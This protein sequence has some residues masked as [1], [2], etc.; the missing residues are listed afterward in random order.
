MPETI[1]VSDI[2]GQ[3]GV[4]DEL[5]K[6]IIKYPNAHIVFGG[7]YIDGH[8]NGHQVV[9]R[10]FAYQ[11]SWPGKVTVLK[12]NH[13]Q[14]M[15]NYLDD[16]EDMLWFT[17]GGKATM[18]Q[19]VRDKYGRA[20][21]VRYMRQDIKV[22]SYVEYIKNLPTIYETENI[23]VVHAG[24]DWS[25]ESPIEDTSEDDRLWIREPYFYSD[26]E[27]K[28]FAHNPTSKTIVSGHT[29]T[30]FVV[31]NFD[32]GQAPYERGIEITCPI[33][34]VQY[35]NEKPRYFIDGGNH[36]GDSRVGNII[37]LDE[38]GMMIDKFEG[39]VEN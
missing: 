36:G 11:E 17:N 18:R 37:V 6:M 9:Q 19:W 2:H 29:P 22:D 7:D 15:L 31:G 5:D 14:L 20:A 24:L 38:S 8:K 13:E 21:S 28:I 34:T 23:V 16:P 10:V 33:K 27:K 35:E 4:F 3:M 26:I 30:V 1:V 12:G 39:W 25:K 32:D